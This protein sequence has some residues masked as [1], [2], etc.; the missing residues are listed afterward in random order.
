MWNVGNTWKS[1]YS[2]VSFAEQCP[3]LRVLDR[4]VRE[5]RTLDGRRDSAMWCEFSNQCESLCS[6][7]T[8]HVSDYRKRCKLRAQNMDKVP[9]SIFSIFTLK[10]K[11]LFFHRYCAKIN[12]FGPHHFCGVRRNVLLLCTNLLWNVRV[13]VPRSAVKSLNSV[14]LSIRPNACKTYTIPRPRLSGTPMKRT[15]C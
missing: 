15:V 7:S 2:P 10:K 4:R 5:S 6:T 12:D 9:K 14:G 13:K 8:R 3:N 1:R 11:K